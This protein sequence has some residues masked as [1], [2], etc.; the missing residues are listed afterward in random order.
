MQVTPLCLSPAGSLKFHKP[1]RQSHWTA[2]CIPIVLLTPIVY[3]ATWYLPS[4]ELPVASQSAVYPACRL[5]RYGWIAG[6]VVTR[7]YHLLW[8][9]LG[10]CVCSAWLCSAFCAY[11][12]RMELNGPLGD[13]LISHRPPKLEN[14]T[15]QTEISRS[16]ALL[17]ELTK[18]K[19]LLS[20]MTTSG[21]WTKGMKATFL[22]QLISGNRINTWDHRSEGSP[23]Y[24]WKTP[25]RK[26]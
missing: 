14:H 16:K 6:G 20:W 22:P 21:E 7:S 8:I 2:C 9:V 15:T 11:S 4:Q 12:S 25:P 1:R 24:F 18:A 5:H 13:W 26:T 23:T 17:T 10:C 19:V 3:F